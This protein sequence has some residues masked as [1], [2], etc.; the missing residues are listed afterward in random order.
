MADGVNRGIIEAHAHGIVTSASL[1][2]TWPGAGD[3]VR[4]ARQHPDL[5]I[6]LH[7]DLTRGPS[8]PALL[9]NLDAVADEIERQLGIFSRLMGRLPTHIDSHHHVH[10]RFNVGRVFVELSERYGLPL[11]GFSPVLYI[12]AFYGQ[13]PPGTSDLRR[14]SAQALVALLAT[15]GP[16]LSQIGC[17]PGYFDTSVADAY[18]REREVELHSLTDVRVRHAVEKEAIRLVSYHDYP[19]LVAAT[20]HLGSRRR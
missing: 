5:S 18:G 17:H 13:W 16:G 14:I 6:G 19:R 8:V 20:A 12:G 7:V 9:S 15:L 1:L 10:L 2:V 4:L 3:A 11:R